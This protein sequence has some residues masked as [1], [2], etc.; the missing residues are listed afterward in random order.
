MSFIDI[1]VNWSGIHMEDRKIAAINDWLVL[2][3]TDHLRLFLGLAGNY[4][5]FVHKF[6][7]QRTQLYA[8]RA[9]KSACWWLRKH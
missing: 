3:S 9:H 7:L 8:S 5:I 2:M 4:M 1:K 6:A